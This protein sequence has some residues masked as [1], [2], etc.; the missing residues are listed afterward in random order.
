MEEE[1][2]GIGEGNKVLADNLRDA[3]FNPNS[4]LAGNV[5]VYCL[6]MLVGASPE[7][8]AKMEETLFGK[9]AVLDEG[10]VQ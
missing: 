4:S 3:F 2:I 8:Y 7:A 10:P 1:M 9:E 5:S 6:S